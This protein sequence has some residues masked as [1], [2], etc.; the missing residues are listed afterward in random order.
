MSDFGSGSASALGIFCAHPFKEPDSEEVSQ[1]VVV[2]VRIDGFRPTGYDDKEVGLSVDP[3]PRA[4]AAAA[5]VAA[6]DESRRE[7]CRRGRRTRTGSP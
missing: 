2:R 3:P 5:T 1:A 6:A 4:A 7:S